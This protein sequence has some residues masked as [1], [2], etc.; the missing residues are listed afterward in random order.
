M[1]TDRG[2]K[3]RPYPLQTPASPASAYTDS[4]AV[5]P[6]LSSF[7]SSSRL[8]NKMFSSSVSSLLPSPGIGITMERTGSLPIQLADV[9]EER[10]KDIEEEYFGFDQVFEPY[11]M[12]SEAYD[13]T[14]HPVYYEIESP[15]RLRSESQSS[16]GLSRFGSRIP[17]RWI[18]TTRSSDGTY[19]TDILDDELRSRANS[20]ASSTSQITSVSQEALPSARSSQDKSRFSGHSLGAISIEKANSAPADEEDEDGAKASTPLLP[21]VWTEFPFT[22][23]N[24]EVASPLQSPTVADVFDEDT[25]PEMTSTRTSMHRSPPLS[26]KPSV[27]SLT[28]RARGMTLR[29]TV[30]G[31]GAPPLVLTEGDDEWSVK[32]GHA[33][34]TIHPE[35]YIPETSDAT[36]FRQFRDDWDL[37]RTNYAK[38]LVRTGEHY[39]ETSMIYKFTKEKW[40]TI[41]AEWKEN[42]ETIVTN[43]VKF[44]AI[45]GLTKSNMSPTEAIKIPRLHDNEKFPELGDEEIVGPMSVAPAIH[46]TIRCKSPRRRNVFRFLHGLV[47]RPAPG[48]AATRA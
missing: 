45:L 41:E 46:S 6:A 21:P 48:I 30:S 40:E 26:T 25:L 36:T 19:V 39:G 13:L 15:K 47:N 16:R 12:P 17:S 28:T 3:E 10:N 14:D 11:G 44:G 2:R 20:A 37:A 35:P 27:A 5:S 22:N 4:T 18:S 43:D 23:P 33:N 7:S 24:S 31:E 42:L 29:T 9:K 1:A 32:L 38:H 8:Q 34:F